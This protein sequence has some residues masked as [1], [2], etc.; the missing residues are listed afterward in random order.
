MI[1]G[2]IFAAAVSCLS[3]TGCAS[4][5]SNS[6]AFTLEK[7]VTYSAPEQAPSYQIWVGLQLTEEQL[8]WNRRPKPS[9]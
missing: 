1:K 4:L 7:D 8:A 3:L 2:N 9:R 5:S 6:K